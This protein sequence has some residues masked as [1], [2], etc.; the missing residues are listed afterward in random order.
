MRS[1]QAASAVG[2]LR[3][4]LLDLDRF[5]EVNDTLGHHC[6]RLAPGAGRSRLD[7]VIRDVDSIARLGGDEFVILLTDLDDPTRGRRRRRTRRDGPVRR[8][9]SS[10][11]SA[12]T[13][14]SASASPSAPVTA[15][16]STSSSSTP[17]SP[18][19]RRR[20]QATGTPAIHPTVTMPA[21]RSSP[22]SANCVRPCNHRHSYVC[23][24]SPRQISSPAKS[25]ASKPSPAGSTRPAACS[26]PPS[27]S[28]S[29]NAPGSSGHSPPR[30]CNKHWRR[31]A[32]G[33]AAGLHLPVSVNISTRSLDEALPGL[34]RGLLHANQVPAGQLELEITE[35]AVMADPDRAIAVLTRLRALGVSLS[36]DD[37]GT[38]YSSMAYLKGLPVQELKIDQSFITGMTADSA[39]TSIVKSC[40]DLARNLH[41]TVVAEGVET[42]GGLGPTHRTRMQLRTGL[43]PDTAALP[44]D[45]IYAWITSDPAA[46]NRPHPQPLGRRVTER[47]SRQPLTGCLAT[48]VPPPSGIYRARLP[49]ETI[50]TMNLEPLVS[51]AAHTQR[52]PQ[53]CRRP[54]CMTSGSPTWPSPWSPSAPSRR[55]GEEAFI[56]SPT[57]L[58][59]GQDPF[60]LTGHPADLACRIYP[61]PNDPSCVPD[62]PRLRPAI[63][64]AARHDLQSGL[65]VSD[66]TAIEG[67]LRS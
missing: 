2:P 28:R 19:T 62:L 29:P 32:H 7:A 27:S 53:R 51:Q 1:K 52:R 12:W 50:P 15:P 6:R 63:K 39:D 24:I 59:G 22:C 31:S 35:S 13:S 30:S 3:S 43:L 25:S 55:P 10:T 64:Q 11:T 21:P 57:V 46:G 34:I 41:L 4:L 54:P 14:R 17:T 23:T 45:E 67:E 44:P 40:V 47:N 5:K 37:F 65:A 16:P 61:N 58:I 66:P 60:A 9:S 26:R 8:R 42:S 38:G 18:C 36:L 49:G 33:T 56:G 48:L 20:P